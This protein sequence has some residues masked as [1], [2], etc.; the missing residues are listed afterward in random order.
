MQSALH[1]GIKQLWMD[2]FHEL[3]LNFAKQ[4]RDRQP[5]EGNKL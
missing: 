1:P 2:K 3:V 5:I 4:I